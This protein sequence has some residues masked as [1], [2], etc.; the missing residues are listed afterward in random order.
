MPLEENLNFTTIVESD[1]NIAYTAEE[2]D[3]ELT[4]HLQLNN[5]TLHFFNEEWQTALKFLRKVVKAFDDK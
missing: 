4:Y 5:F 2:P 1:E 3:G